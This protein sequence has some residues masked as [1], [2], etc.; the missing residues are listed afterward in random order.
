MMYFSRLMDLRFLITVKLIDS[1]WSC[2][3][4]QNIY[5]L[6]ITPSMEI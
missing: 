2:F 4:N 3:F 6:A 1:L 5:E